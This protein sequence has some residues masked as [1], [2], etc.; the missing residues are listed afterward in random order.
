[1]KYRLE[2]NGDQL[3]EAPDVNAEIIPNAAIDQ[4]LE[5]PNVNPEIKNAADDHSPEIIDVP[6]ELIDVNVDM[7]NAFNKKR[8]LEA[9]ED[10]SDYEPNKRG[11]NDDVDSSQESKDTDSDTDSLQVSKSADADTAGGSKA[12]SLY[13]NEQSDG[14]E[15]AI[16]KYRKLGLKIGPEMW[17]RIRSDRDYST[18]LKGRTD[19]SFRNRHRSNIEKGRIPPIKKENEIFEKHG[20]DIAAHRKMIQEKDKRNEEKVEKENENCEK[21]GLDIAAIRKVIQEENKI[22]QSVIA[23]EVTSSVIN[24]LAP[25][26]EETIHKAVNKTLGSLFTSLSKVYSEK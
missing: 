17:K 3:L 19:S 11:R 5:V 8:S 2:Q 24:K 16:D 18:L 21:Y 14:L 15:Y 6:S 1:M 22:N 13:T 12:G 26:F 4:P 20:L 7:P 9:G 10:D 25:E 23:N